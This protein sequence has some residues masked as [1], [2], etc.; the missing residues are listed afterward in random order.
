MPTAHEVKLFKVLIAALY[1]SLC[2]VCGAMDRLKLR[3]QKAGNKH[4]QS[5]SYNNWTHDHYVSC[6]FL[7]F[8]NGRIGTCYINTPGTYHDSVLAEMGGV[9]KKIGQMHRNTGEKV[10]VDLAFA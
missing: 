5:M 10:V 3:L 6:L 7:F 2:N 4:E 8:P 9:Y 1:P